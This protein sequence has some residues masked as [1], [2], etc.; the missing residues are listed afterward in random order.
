ML[1]NVLSIWERPV[2]SKT[3]YRRP[4][5]TIILITIRRILFAFRAK[6]LLQYVN[7]FSL[8]LMVNPHEHFTQKSH[9][10]QLYADDYQKSTK[11]NQRPAANRISE[12]DFVNCE[13]EQD[14]KS[15]NAA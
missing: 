9:S 7:R 11:Q 1:L 5:L 12:K 6:D 4:E 3:K 15:E 2:L 14:E 10:D 13:I 8:T